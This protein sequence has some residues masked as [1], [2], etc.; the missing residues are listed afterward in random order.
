ML[1]KIFKTNGR[2]RVTSYTFVRHRLQSAT[3]CYKI[4][5]EDDDEY[6]LLDM[7]TLVTSQ[8]LQVL[9]LAGELQALGHTRPFRILDTSGNILCG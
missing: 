4:W 5:L 7:N 2:M 6:I 9:L 1:L 3:E 8:E